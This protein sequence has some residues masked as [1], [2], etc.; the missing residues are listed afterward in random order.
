MGLRDVRRLAL[1]V[2]KEIGGC[3]GGYWEVGCPF[4][5]RRRAVGMSMEEE[6]RPR[7]IEITRPLNLEI[8][9]LGNIGVG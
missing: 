8:T 5:L 3:E 4:C 2:V 1:W 6:E 7:L 9:R